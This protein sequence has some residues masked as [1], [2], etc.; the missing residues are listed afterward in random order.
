MPIL[1]AWQE[2]AP[3]ACSAVTMLPD[4]AGDAALLFDPTSSESI[5][6]AMLKMWTSAPLRS[7]LARLGAERLRHFTWEKTAKAYRAVYRRAAG[8]PL[9]EE[10]RILLRW[11][12]MREPEPPR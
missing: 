3:V 8:W 7:E 6:D 1:E 9:T 12:W 2:G 4:Q 10:D 5:A 11:D